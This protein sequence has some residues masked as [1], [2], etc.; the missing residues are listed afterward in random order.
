MKDSFAGVQS[1]CGSWFKERWVERFS[2]GFATV[3]RPEQ[4]VLL[5]GAAARVAWCN[6]NATEEIA[7]TLIAKDKGFARMKVDEGLYARVEVVRSR[8]DAEALLRRW[9][10]YPI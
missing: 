4:R 5:P 9:G 10:A 2:A 8:E 6:R 7:S 1:I 3:L